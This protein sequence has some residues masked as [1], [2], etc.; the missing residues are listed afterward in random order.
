MPVPKIPRPNPKTGKVR[1]YDVHRK[2]YIE[3]PPPNAREM[4]IVGSAVANEGDMPYSEAS[5]REKLLVHDIDPRDVVQATS[6][7]SAGTHEDDEKDDG[8]SKYY[9]LTKDEL[10]VQIE[11]RQL[12]MPMKQ[13]EMVLIALLEED[14]EREESKQAVRDAQRAKEAG[15]GDSSAETEPP[16]E[17]KS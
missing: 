13:N 5:A 10:K 8:S 15:E 7:R 6:K 14:D 2:R 4:F 3:T 16:K 17:N 12:E 11:Q 1:I 9:G